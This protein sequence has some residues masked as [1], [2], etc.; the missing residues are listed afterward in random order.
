MNAAS[1]AGSTFPTPQDLGPF[2]ASVIEEM[3]RTPSDELFKTMV[4][5]GIYTESGKL[6]KEYGGRA[7]AK[8]QVV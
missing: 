5:S 2:F 6:T 4:T 8:K 3:R 7:H 1:K